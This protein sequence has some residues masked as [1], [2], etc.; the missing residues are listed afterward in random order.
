MHLNSFFVFYLSTNTSLS[1]GVCRIIS[2]KIK[3]HTKTLPTAL[4]AY[5]FIKFSRMDGGNKSVEQSDVKI[6]AKIK[7]PIEN[8]FLLLIINQ[9]A[10]QTIEMINVGDSA[11]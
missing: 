9:I 4:I 7:T 8:L 1:L 3:H 11:L 2:I 10:I 6:K 5:G